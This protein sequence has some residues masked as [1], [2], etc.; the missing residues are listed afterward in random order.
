MWRWPGWPGSKVASTCMWTITSHHHHIKQERH[1]WYAVL[2]FWWC[3][4]DE[5]SYS[6][7]AGCCHQLSVC[8]LFA[9]VDDGV[10]DTTHTS[11]HTWRHCAKHTQRANQRPEHEHEKITNNTVF[12][13]SP[14]SQN[15]Y[16]F[17]QW[18]GTIIFKNSVNILFLLQTDQTN[19]DN[20]KFSARRRDY[21]Y[22][23]VVTIVMSTT[24]QDGKDE[25]LATSQK[26]TSKQHAVTPYVGGNTATPSSWFFPDSI[27]NY[28]PMHHYVKEPLYCECSGTTNK[29]RTKSTF[30]IGLWKLY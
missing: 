30:V 28:H 6:W 3:T 11:T 27:A 23:G 19:T 10:G 29:I 13:H 12:M 7:S 17:T 4:D 15:R 9:P 20:Q 8:R 16:L 22:K 21:G 1:R 18:F 14:L 26:A 24:P 25:Y 2:S 5:F